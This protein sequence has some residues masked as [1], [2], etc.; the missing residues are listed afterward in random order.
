MCPIYV[1]TDGAPPPLADMTEPKRARAE[2]VARRY[3][4][5]NRN[6]PRLK[7]ISA[8]QRTG[9]LPQGNGALTAAPT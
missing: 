4:M 1:E 5:R 6:N 8:H 7:R 2:A 3:G 9:Q